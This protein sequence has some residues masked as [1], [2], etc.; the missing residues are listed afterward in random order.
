M[1][2]MILIEHGSTDLHMVT[3]LM[4]S[5]QSGDGILRWIH[6]TNAFQ[7]AYYHGCNLF[8]S[9]LITRGNDSQSL[10]KKMCW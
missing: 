7:T 1:H 8:K 6:T 10:K 4:C 5:M 2:S 9:K 3:P